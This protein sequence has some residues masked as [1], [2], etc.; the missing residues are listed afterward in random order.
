MK[1]G[2]NALLTPHAIFESGSN[3]SI[4]SAFFIICLFQIDEFLT[5]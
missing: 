2:V 4:D 1:V 3:I 5:K